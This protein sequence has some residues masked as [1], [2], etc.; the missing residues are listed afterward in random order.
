ML[1]NDIGFETPRLRLRVIQPGD[2]EFLAGLDSDPVVM[3]YI[4][5]GALSPKEAMQWAEAQIEMAP[6]RWHLRK[7]IVELRDSGTKVG[8]MELAKF[9]GVFDPAENN[10]SDDVS[11]GFELARAYWNQGFAA[12]AA[13]P[14]LGYA[15]CTLDLK[16]V[17]AF[18]HPDNMRSARVLE[19]LGFRQHAT[20]RHQD[21][22]G[23]ECRLYAL[24]ADGWQP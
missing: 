3:Q 19:K 7:W 11:L 15:F 6:H 2:E 4:H 12:E 8:W 14:V 10:L 5:S 24:L 23:N 16:R 17:V 9:R 1:E 18:V 22:G 21:E 13:W 20:G